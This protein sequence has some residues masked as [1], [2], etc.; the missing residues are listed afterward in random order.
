[1][2]FFYL[3]LSDIRKAVHHCPERALA[4]HLHEGAECVRSL[5]ASPGVRILK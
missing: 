3:R 4:D 5:I 1:M 2:R